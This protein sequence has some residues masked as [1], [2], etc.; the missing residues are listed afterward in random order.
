MADHGGV[1]YVDTSALVKL[2]VREAESDA[3]ERELSRW[4]GAAT[5]TLT[6]VELGRAIL[7][8]QGDR[9]D[10][11]SAVPLVVLA[12]FAHVPMTARVL[13]V[14][15]SILP[16]VLRTLDAIHLASA[17]ALG[18]D[19]GAVMTYDARLADAVTTHGITVVAPT[20]DG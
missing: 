20:V 11:G 9:R 14:A 3:V 2:V 13:S 19:L 15:R 16:P 17:L 10:L 6:D 4:P 5:S 7:R 8:A 12:G 18:A 1:L